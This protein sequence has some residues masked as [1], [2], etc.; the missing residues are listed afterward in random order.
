M[1]YLRIVHKYLRVLHV[2]AKISLMTSL[3]S[4]G[5]FFIGV[6]AKM[7]RA[8]LVVVFFQAI[9]FNVSSFAGWSFD[10]IILLTT[11]YLTFEIIV[12][13]TFHR[14]LAYWFPDL[15][16]RGEFDLALIRPISPLFFVSFRIIDWFDITSLP[17]I[18]ILW[19][20]VFTRTGFVFTAPDF[21]LFLVFLFL[22]IVLYFG[23]MIFLGGVAFWTINPQGVGRL[24]ERIFMAG[25][26]PASAFTGKVRAVLLFIL[27]VSLFATL[28][29]EILL[30]R[31]D[32]S[33]LIFAIIVTL[34]VFFGSLWF[35]KFALKHHSSASS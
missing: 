34:L 20:Y 22:G 32:F 12:V 2:M 7:L 21:A 8:V 33:Y 13:I 10:E 14:N 9:F 1:K 18:I 27:P 3:S 29:A 31:F 28:P 4:R 16:L 24:M 11:I 15:L 26:Y 19:W 30:H 25:R 23:L 17:P 5:T 6:F 35:W